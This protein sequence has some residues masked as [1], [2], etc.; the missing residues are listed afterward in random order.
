MGEDLELYD[1]NYRIVLSDLGQSDFLDSN[2]RTPRT[3]NTGT[4]GFAAPELIL[5]N[6]D[7]NESVDIWSLGHLLYFLAFNKWPYDEYNIEDEHKLYQGIIRKLCQ[8]SMSIIWI[9]YV[10]LLYMDIMHIAY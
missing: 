5:N 1:T 9:F 4:L 6:N 3:G 8:F 2:Q 7:W 10:N